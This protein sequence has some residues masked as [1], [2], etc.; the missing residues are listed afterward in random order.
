[1]KIELRTEPKGPYTEYEVKRGTAVETIYKDLAKKLPYKVLMAK[2]D[3]RYVELT[4]KLYKGCKVEFLDIRNRA[5]SLVY[6]NSISLIFLKAFHEVVPG[7]K[8]TID[9]YLSQGLYVVVHRKGG[10]TAEEVSA[11]SKRMRELIDADLPIVSEVMD[12]DAALERLRK[13]G[14]DARLKLLESVPNLKHVPYYDLD[15]ERDFFYGLMTP[16][17]GYIDKFRLKR[18]HGNI[19][20]RMPIPA[21][22]G[23]VPKF[24]D[25]KRLYEAFL[26][27]TEWDSILGVDYVS[28]LNE[29]I[30]RG[31]YE[32]LI[33]LDE[34]LH[35][36][37]IAGI[38]DMIKAQ[39]KR[40]ILIAGP[41]SSGKTTFAKRLCTQLMVNGLKPMYMGTD[42]YFVNR[43]DTPLDEHGEYNYEDLDALDIELFNN[44]MNALLAGETVDMPVYDFIKGEKIFGT[45]MTQISG[46]TPIVIEGIHAL[47][48]EL[49]KF[50]PKKQ[51]F[52][53]Y[54]SPL[55]QLN[56]DRHNRVRS[57]DGRLIRRMVRDNRT[58][59]YSAK[60][61]LDNWPKVRAG[62]DK[63][64][65]PY[66][67]SADV[68]FNSFHIY[69]LAVLKKYVEPLLKEITPDDP[70]Y[71]EADRVLHFIRFFRSIDD[72]SM[73]SNYSILRE[74][75]GGSVIHK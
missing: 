60:A 38:A 40:I 30:R 3:N 15:G 47:N 56:I 2:V 26:R 73:I 53:I 28:E 46:D 21:H 11:I 67:D 63:N 75:I 59:G 27:Q 43:E 13:H 7:I 72:D 35:E 74:F 16:S 1:M 37:L 39:K 9:N 32:E 6:Q 62:E 49:T 34:A 20:I 48:D 22:P 42:D 50:I 69:E 33:R 52:K 54:I 65:T 41:S 23:S 14:M 29:R 68:F 5:A 71:A 44:N 19:L 8:A 25:E 61:T 4:Y 36:K 57:A 66:A 58:R 10:I 55:N 24:N 12:K 17:T 51:K 31:E 64:I 45:R 18:Y 70:Q